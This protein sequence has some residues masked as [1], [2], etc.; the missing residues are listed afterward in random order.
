[1]THRAGLGDRHLY[2]THAQSQLS[3]LDSF[4]VQLHSDD[5]RTSADIIITYQRGCSIFPLVS[6]VTGPVSSYSWIIVA[7]EID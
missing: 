5:S 3:S 6:N 7:R 4:A 1:M 2:T